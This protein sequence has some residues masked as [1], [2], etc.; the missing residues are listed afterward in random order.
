MARPARELWALHD[1]GPYTTCYNSFVAGDRLASGTRSWKRWPP[2]RME[3]SASDYVLISP[4]PSSRGLRCA[5]A[6]FEQQLFD[7][8]R[9]SCRAE[10]EAL[11]LVATFGAQPVE[12]VHGFDAFRRGRDVEAAAKAGDRPHDRNAIGTIRQILHERAIDLD[13]VERKAPEIAEA[14]ISGAEIIHGNADPEFAQLMQDREIGLGLRQEHRFGIFKL[15]PLWRQSGMRQCRDHHLNQV[16]AAKL[17]RRQI[18]G[19][20][21]IRGPFHRFAAGFPQHPL[22]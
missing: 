6:E 10:Q 5:P 20:L 17:H 15:E 7:L 1:F 14:G 4:R 18:D 2:L 12:L 21:D 3:L 16:A 8:G 9:G 11:H 13:L 19:D 22:A